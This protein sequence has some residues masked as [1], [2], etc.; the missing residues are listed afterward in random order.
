[1]DYSCG[2]SA[3]TRLLRSRL[4][5]L[6]RHRETGVTGMLMSLALYMGEET[7]RQRR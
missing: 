7:I 3:D 6:A 5:F 4:L 1:M 2:S